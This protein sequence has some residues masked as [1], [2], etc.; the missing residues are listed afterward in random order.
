MAQSPTHRF[1]QIIGDLLEAAMSPILQEFANEYD[2]YLDHKGPRPC[3]RGVKCTWEDKNGNR[4]DLDYVLESGGSPDR[5]GTPV[6]F[7][8]S[9]WRRYTKHS[10][11][12]AQEIQGAIEPLAETYRQTLPFKGAILAGEFTTGALDQLRSLGFNIVYFPYVAV[13]DAFGRVGIDASTDETTPD[14]LVQDKVEQ[15][16]RLPED[17][18]GIVV[19]ALLERNRI[20]IDQFLAALH[21]AVSRR[22]EEITVLPLHGTALQAS[23]VTD[24]VTLLYGYD[25]AASQA[26]FERYEIRILFRNK[27]EITGKFNDKPSAIEFLNTYQE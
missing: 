21:E 11:N 17:R 20:G 9:A 25:E 1:G 14:E 10:R 16:E 2:L 15:W 3:R 12:K 23:S 27:N 26:N 24:A 18:K 5:F 13:V 6:A 22:I 7:I 8:E 4:H 19:Q